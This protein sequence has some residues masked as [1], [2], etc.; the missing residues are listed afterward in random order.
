MGSS[1]LELVGQRHADY[2]DLRFASKVREVLG[3]EHVT[4]G[5]DAT[6]RELV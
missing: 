2:L 4:C 6:S 5:S 1:D 3:M